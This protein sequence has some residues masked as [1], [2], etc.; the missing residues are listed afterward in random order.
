M[1]LC[2][3]VDVSAG[4][5]E[6]CSC[7]GEAFTRL[8]HPCRPTYLRVGRYLMRLLSYPLNRFGL[9]AYHLPARALSLSHTFFFFFWQ[10]QGAGETAVR[11]ST[12]KRD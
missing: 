5:K 3:V 6:R 9:P 2:L 12:T 10:N 7:D 11:G 8:V 4:K 1:R